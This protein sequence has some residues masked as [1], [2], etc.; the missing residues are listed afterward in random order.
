MTIRWFQLVG[1]SYHG[2]SGPVFSGVAQ[3]RVGDACEAVEADVISE[4]DGARWLLQNGY[5]RISIGIEFRAEKKGRQLR[6]VAEIGRLL[7]VD[8]SVVWPELANATVPEIREYL[9]P[10]V[11]EA[12]EFAGERKGLG[13]LVPAGTGGELRAVPLRPLIEDPMPYVEEQADCFVITRELPPDLSPS[14]RAGVMARYDRDLEGLL[15]KRALGRIVD[16]ETSDRAVRWV[17][18][19]PKRRR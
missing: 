15:T 11:L 16:L 9:K 7:D 5:E 1:G 14:E 2:M 4:F 8:Y 19:V 13:P 12:L 10:V 17:I 3:D 6:S 18:E